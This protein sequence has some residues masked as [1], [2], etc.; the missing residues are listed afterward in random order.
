MTAIKVK[1]W[2]MVTKLYIAYVRHLEYC[3]QAWSP[4]Y[5]KDC[6]LLER[7]QKGQLKLYKV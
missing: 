4:T 5:D 6:W 1:R 2:L 3:V 7:A